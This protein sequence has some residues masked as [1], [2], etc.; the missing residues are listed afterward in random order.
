MK[1]PIYERQVGETADT[2][3]RMLTAQVSPATFA[4]PYEAAAKAGGAA[5]S[6]GLAWYEHDLK[7]KRST[8]QA[9]AE[10]E[11]AMFSKDTALQITKGYTDAE[12]NWVP[13]IDPLD[14]E[15]EY[16]ARRGKRAA[17]ISLLS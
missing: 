9:R 1:V 17:E 14:Q 5:F 7:L 4:A 6:A 11:L 10:Q 15:E 3:G 12:G 13:P 2:G 16:K 8:E